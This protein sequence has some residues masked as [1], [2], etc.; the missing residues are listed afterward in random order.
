MSEVFQLSLDD[1]LTLEADWRIGGIAD[2]VGQIASYIISTLEQAFN[3]AVSGF[4]TV[5]SSIVNTAIGGVNSLL[6][7][8]SRNI[9][10]VLLTIQSLPNTISSSLSGI[11]SQ[12]SSILNGVVGSISSTI[13]QISYAVSSGFNSILSSLNSAFSN[14]SSSVNTSIRSI[15]GSISGTLNSIVNSIS[16]IVSQIGGSLSSI[17]QQILNSLEN[18]FS[19]LSSSFNETVKQIN[20]FLQ[21]LISQ[22]QTALPSMEKIIV[23]LAAFG[24]NPIVAIQNGLNTVLKAFGL[25]S[26]DDIRHEIE[27]AL[28]GAIPALK[29]LLDTLS[30]INDTVNSIPK[31]L[32]DTVTSKDFLNTLTNTVTNTIKEVVVLP[33]EIKNFFNSATK[34]LD[35]LVEQHSPSILDDFGSALTNIIEAFSATGIFGSLLQSEAW[36][37]FLSGKGFAS[38]IKTD[39]NFFKPLTDYLSQ[40]GSGIVPL[41][42]DFITNVESGFN[43]LGNFIVDGIIKTSGLPAPNAS[44]TDPLQKLAS[45]LFDPK[46]GWAAKIAPTLRTN[47]LIP[48]ELVATAIGEVSLITASTESAETLG[49]IA[50]AAHPTK[51]LQIKDLMHEFFERIG[52][53][54]VTAVVG[55]TLVGASFRPLMTRWWNKQSQLQLVGVRELMEM[56]D[57]KLLAPA[58]LDEYLQEHGYDKTF[59]DSLIQIHYQPPSIR[60]LR[61]MWMVGSLTQNDIEE[62]FHLTNM[63]P[64]YIPI[65]AASVV[66]QGILPF[67]RAQAAAFQVQVKNGFETITTFSDMLKKINYPSP[68]IQ[69][70]LDAATIQVE[71]TTDVLQVAEYDKQ[72]TEGYMNRADY[73]KNITPLFKNPDILKIHVQIADLAVQRMTDSRIRTASDRSISESLADYA[74]GTLSTKDFEAICVAAKKTPEEI[75]AL[76]AARQ[77]MYKHLVRTVKFRNYQGALGKGNISPAQFEALSKALPIDNTI[78]KATEQHIILGM[79]KAAKITPTAANALLA[80]AGIPL[81]TA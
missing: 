14:L 71:E 67:L 73:L 24:A 26:L 27:N 25:P 6:G 37:S 65:A 11:T 47:S 15:S 8:V 21:P 43:D 36:K 49:A 41:L 72:Y 23:F 55:A 76:E 51:K 60:I 56:F 34:V 30:S 12:V 45:S 70:T 64:K 66:L 68:F 17:G 69:P 32:V 58:E 53:G 80:Q 61:S 75:T 77:A 9:S 16:S 33:E 35:K 4:Q 59:R 3:F 20:T 50:D 29:P 18:A 40:L 22:L 57:R 39:T 63:M 5:V 7:S 2:P 28:S 48:A 10:Q 46:T 54:N 74:T 42:Q 81:T 19:Q 78:M 31:T 79:V 13:T 38:T 1:L 52:L 44:L 62:I